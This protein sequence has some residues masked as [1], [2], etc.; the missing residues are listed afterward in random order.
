MSITIATGEQISKSPVNNS[1]SKQMFSF[2]KSN[3]FPKDNDLK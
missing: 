3:R 2:P 1:K